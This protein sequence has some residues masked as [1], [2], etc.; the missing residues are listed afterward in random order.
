MEAIV[1]AHAEG[2]WLRQKLV[3]VPELV[4]RG[5]KIVLSYSDAHLQAR[6]V[7]GA[8]GEVPCAGVANGF[9]QRLF[10]ERGI[11]ERRREL[12]HAQ[13]PEE[14]LGC[15]HNLA[16]SKAF[17]LHEGGGIGGGREH[18]WDGVV[19]ACSVT[20]IHNC[21]QDAR[22]RTSFASSLSTCCLE[23]ARGWAPTCPRCR[24]CW[25]SLG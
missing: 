20:C 21:T 22:A 7:I 8:V 14:A 2:E 13:T 12:A 16:G 17:L 3:I 6:I 23:N 15:A 9:A 11:P 1:R 4:L 24:S 10:E 5:D 19:S 18:D 25:P